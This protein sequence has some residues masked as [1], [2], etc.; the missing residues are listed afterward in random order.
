MAHKKSVL[1]ASDHA[2]YELKEYLKREISEI[3]WVDEGPSSADRTD[4]PD[5]AEKVATKVAAGNPAQGVLVCGS[6]IGMCISANKVDG[7]RAA[8]VESEQTARLSREHNDAN[9]V[10]LGSRILTPEYAK[11]IVQTWLGTGFEG[12]RHADR[13]RKISELEKRNHGASSRNAQKK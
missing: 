13:V 8:V 12:G 7:V 4:Y 3:D 1:I 6:G 5:F 11:S 2:G 10:C 9:I